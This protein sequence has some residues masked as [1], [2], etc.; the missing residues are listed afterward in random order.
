MKE[1]CFQ[2]TVIGIKTRCNAVIQRFS[3]VVIRPSVTPLHQLVEWL[4]IKYLYIFLTVMVLKGQYYYGSNG[5]HIDFIFWKEIIAF[6]G[7]SLT[8]VFLLIFRVQDF[9]L[10]NLIRVLFVLYFIPVNSAFAINNASFGFF[11]LSHLYFLLLV[12]CSYLADRFVLKRVKKLHPIPAS[13]RRDRITNRT[14]NALFF[15][16]CILYIIHKIGYNGLDFSLSLASED[17]YGTRA[18]YQVYLQEISGTLFAY[19]LALV[20]YLVSA[21]VAFYIVSALSRRKW[22]AVVCLVITV[23]SMYSVAMQKSILFVPLLAVIIYLC[24]K[25]KILRNFDR[26][27]VLG[28]ILLLMGCVAEHLIL[29]SDRIYTLFVRREM[30]YP[31]WLNHL[32]YDFFSENPKVMWTQNV[33][34]MQ[35]LLEPVY[36]ISPLDLISNAYFGG[37]IPSPNTGLFAEAYM[38]FGFAGILLY[39]LGLTAVFCVLSLIYREY[40]PAFSIVMML[41]LALSLTNVSI[42]RTDSVISIFFF[43]A[44]VFIIPRL[45]FSPLRERLSSIRLPKFQK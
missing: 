5:Y 11:F 29:G 36:D 31:A 39:P 30:Y 14:L 32:Y 16:I 22:S 41:K 10:G 18:D 19:A 15:G 24:G 21:I 12:G 27:F 13:L 42:V 17:V 7:F 3:D 20:R 44:I 37:Q 33:F 34:L 2:R 23:L 40:G 25:L 35:N 9:F 1:N 45:N 43:A 26:V 6:V 38:H 4:L 8:A 28:I